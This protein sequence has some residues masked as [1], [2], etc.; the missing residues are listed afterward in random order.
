MVRFH[1]LWNNYIARKFDFYLKLCLS[2]S[3]EHF[4]IHFES[5]YHFIITEERHDIFI[6]IAPQ[7]VTVYPQESKIQDGRSISLHCLIDGTPSVVQPQIGWSWHL[8]ASTPTVASSTS[9]PKYI[10]KSMP[11]PVL[12]RQ[13]SVNAQPLGAM[14]S[15]LKLYGTTSR[16]S[17]TYVCQLS[18]GFTVSA[19]GDAQL[20]VLPANGI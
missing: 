16:A 6:M 7:R 2:Q 9:V 12:W 10:A 1:L 17:G 19:R 11:D 15:T 13:S 3:V 8:N 18:N 5:F 20:S 4:T 14:N